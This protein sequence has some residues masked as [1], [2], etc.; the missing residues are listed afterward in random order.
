MQAQRQ[1]LIQDRIDGRE[2]V[3]Y[4]AEMKRL[5]KKSSG[6]QSAWDRPWEQLRCA[7]DP[8]GRLIR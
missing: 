1:Q 2:W 3:E 7:V 5:K 6:Y 4:V 8:F